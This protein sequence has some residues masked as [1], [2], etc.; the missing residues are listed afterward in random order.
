MARGDF[1]KHVTKISCQCEVASLV[2][3][4]APES[5]P[6]S[7]NLTTSDAVAHYHH[8]VCVSVVRAAITVLPHRPAKLGHGQNDHV[9]H[10][11][12]QVGVERSEAG[13]ELLQQVC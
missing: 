7:V 2:K 4:I 3:L 10:S 1:A 6:L 13:T 5:G 11:L 8:R 12:A 9:I